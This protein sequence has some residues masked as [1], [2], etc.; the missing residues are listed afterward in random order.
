VKLFLILQWLL[1]YLDL[2]TVLLST[3]YFI[4]GTINMHLSLFNVKPAS[5]SF[6]NTASVYYSKSSLLVAGC[7]SVCQRPDYSHN[8]DLQHQNSTKYSDLNNTADRNSQ[9]ENIFR[10]IPVREN[11]SLQSAHPANTSTPPILPYT[12]RSGRTVRQ[13]CIL[14]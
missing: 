7:R 3:R 6:C 11:P 2:L 5:F 12:T 9:S 14:Y 13:P 10:N 4:L 8:D 1:F